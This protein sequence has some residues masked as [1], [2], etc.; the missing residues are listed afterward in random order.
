MKVI[1][2][3]IDG[4]LAWDTWKDGKVQITELTSKPFEIPYPWVQE[5]CDA[6]TKIVRDTGA[7]LVISSDWRKYFSIKQLNAIFL[8]Y[9]IPHWS[10]LDTTTHFNPRKKMSSSPE[11]DRA[12]E[13]HSW[14][15]CFRPHH[16][17][18]IDD[19]P[20]NQYFKTLRIPRW[21]H[22]QVDGDWGQGGRLRDKVD[23][24]IKL[25]ER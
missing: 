8:T 6:L 16:W 18:A 17:V 7:H 9:G 22:V 3:D 11:W 24:V 13:I 20:L 15:K 14:V 19:M 21:R 4:P 5:D 23:K 12:C 25:L 1:F 2:I 10:I